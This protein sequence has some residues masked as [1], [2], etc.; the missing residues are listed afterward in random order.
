MSL[1]FILPAVCG[2]KLAWYYQ[3][4]KLSFLLCTASNRLRFVD[5]RLTL[6]AVLNYKEQK[7]VFL[8]FCFRSV[9]VSFKTK[10]AL[11]SEVLK[12]TKNTRENKQKNK[13]KDVKFLLFI[14]YLDNIE[15]TL[16]KIFAETTINMV[17]SGN[18][19]YNRLNM[20]HYFWKIK[21]NG[22]RF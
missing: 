9:L 10:K 12:R 1:D 17:K 7:I 20:F 16:M 13:Q 8:F 21:F 3:G 4:D 19:F 11:A 14:P 6:L 15:T 18:F 22:S 2:A 5:T